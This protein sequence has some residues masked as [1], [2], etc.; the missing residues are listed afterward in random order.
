MTNRI[1]LIAPA[2]FVVALAASVPALSSTVV[3]GTC[4]PNK[5]SFDSLTDAVQGVPTGSTIQVCPGAYAEQLVISKSLT[6]KGIT[7]GNGAYPVVKPPAGG[8]VNN[9]YG[10]AGSGFWGQGTPFAAQILIQG[11]ASVTLTNIAIDATGSNISSCDPVVVGVLVQDSSATL[12]GVAVKNQLNPCANPAVGVGVLTQNDSPSATTITVKN[13]TFV[14]AGQSFEADGAA[15]T[16]TLTNNSFAGNPTTSYNA[17]SIETGNSTIQGN[18]IS[19]FSYPPASA[20]PNAAAYGIYLSCVPGAT[21][22]NNEIA[23]TQV[24][25]FVQNGCTTTAVSVTNN[26]ISDA[27]LI[28]IDAGGTNGLIQGNDIRTAQ[29]AI[30]I[31]GGSAGNIIQNN[32][33]NDACAAIGSNPAAGANTILTNSVS[34]AI[35]L[36]LVNS[37]GLCP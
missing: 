10:L 1:R 29:T 4:M 30:R 19:N 37:T 6:L 3:V 21:V 22:T 5:V 15:N 13:T 12:N 25:I 16:S 20:D 8:L 28:G 36:T 18:T 34:N 33:I 17:I 9:A 24:G 32:T 31:P 7:V 23:T 14:N 11:G 26:K 35:N 2:C 27:Q